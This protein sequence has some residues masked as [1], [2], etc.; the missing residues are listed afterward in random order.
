MSASEPMPWQLSARD[1][2][3]PAS[4]RPDADHVQQLPIGRWTW[5]DSFD[6]RLYRKGLRLREWPCGDNGLH[7]LLETADGRILAEDD[8]RAR[9]ADD[10][11]DEAMHER[12]APVLEMRALLPLASVVLHGQRHAVRDGNAK[13]IAQVYRYDITADAGDDG[14]GL[15]P[16]I[17]IEPLKGYAAETDALRQQAEDEGL[18][19]AAE[20]LFVAALAAHDRRPGDYSSKINLRL[21]PDKPAAKAARAI[22]R[23]LLTTLEANEAG[24]RER[25]DSEFLHDFRV[26]I[27][28]TRSALGRIKGVFPPAAT[29]HFRDEFAWLQQA[30]S[31]P[32]DLD[33]YLLNMPEYEASLPTA[34]RGDL[35]PL[36]TFLKARRDQAYRELVAVLDSDRYRQ[37]LADWRAFLDG[38]EVGPRGRKRARKVADRC[39][40]KAWS[41]LVSEGRA[42]HED[43]PAE[44]LHELRKSCKKLRYVMEFFRSLYPRKRIAGLIRELKDL[45][46][47]LGDFHDFHVQANALGEF[48]REM[49]AAGEAPPETLLAMGRL[50]EGL[51]ARAETARA[52]FATRFARF[53]RRRNRRRF[54]ELLQ[55][56]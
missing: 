53:D 22:Q 45:Q 35:A 11:D 33:V 27:R 9:F 3:L 19:P 56:S 31:Q 17:A 7:R 28:R 18:E 1:E 44:A 5:L 47:N 15:P 43:S 39:I 12:L 32:R 40:Y 55:G 34:A 6:W 10:I 37:L 25:I 24:T 29:A 41:R 49:S 21:H 46:E 50:I 52:E 26:A 16:R 2:A 38:D 23:N 54:H 51:E 8:S 30:T 48:S 20:S 14:V 36:R 42:I 13:I 4:L